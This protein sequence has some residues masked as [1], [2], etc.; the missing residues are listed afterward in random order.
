MPNRLFIP[1]FRVVSLARRRGNK[2]VW[3]VKIRLP[4]RRAAL[5]V[6]LGLLPRLLFVVTAFTRHILSSSSSGSALRWR[7]LRGWRGFGPGLPFAADA[8]RLAI[9][10]I[11]LKLDRN[12]RICAVA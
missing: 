5:R 12:L 10:R 3:V 9:L 6:T 8:M 4:I 11:G 7:F 2:I 1:Q